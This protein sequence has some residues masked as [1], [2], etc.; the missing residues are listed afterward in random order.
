VLFKT[1]WLGFVST[2]N[3]GSI[4]NDNLPQPAFLDVMKMPSVAQDSHFIFNGFANGWM[5]DPAKVCKETNACVRRA[6][7]KLTMDLV[8][9]FV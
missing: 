2:K 8:I 5:L 7:G 4:Q 1:P 9:G 6:D 3:E